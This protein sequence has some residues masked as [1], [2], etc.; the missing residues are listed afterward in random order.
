M[1]PVNVTRAFG[2]AL[3]MIGLL[4]AQARGAEEQG[5]VPVERRSE[6]VEKIGLMIFPPLIWSPPAIGIDVERRTLSN[7]IIL[8]LYPDRT[9][10]LFELVGLIRTGRLYEPAEKPEIGRAS[11]RERV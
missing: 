9:L 2:A 10:P 1:M 8:Y 7:G 11:C 5:A 3:V 6:G 4:T